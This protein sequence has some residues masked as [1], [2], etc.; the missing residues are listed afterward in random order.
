MAISSPRFFRS[1]S[2]STSTTNGGNTTA[3]GVTNAN[4]TNGGGVNATG[5]SVGSLPSGITIRSQTQTTGSFTVPNM[6][7]V[8]IP[9]TRLN[10]VTVYN[11]PEQFSAVESLISLLDAQPAQVSIQA[12]L[13][14]VSA[15]SLKN[16]GALFQ[17]N[18][19]GMAC[20][21][22]CHDNNLIG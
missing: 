18:P 1:S 9:D 11:S 12:S 22:F 6:G 15:S 17:Y 3:G 16:L 19:S 13:V 2:S 4:T 7:S 5:S 20:I 10:T 21:H 8:A 14:E